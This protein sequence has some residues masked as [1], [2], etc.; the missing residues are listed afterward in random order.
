MAASVGSQNEGPHRVRKAHQSD[1]L[2]ENGFS[3]WIRNQVER[4]VAAVFPGAD[5]GAAP[6]A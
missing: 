5:L 1:V 2:H 3:A 4:P 6:D